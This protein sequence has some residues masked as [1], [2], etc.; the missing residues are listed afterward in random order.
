M[1]TRFVRFNVVG[2]LGIGVRLAVV[3]VLVDRAGMHY[4]VATALAVEVA[5]LHNFFW[6]DR[7]T[8]ADGRDAAT[9]PGRLFLRCLAFHAGNGLVSM[10]GSL[11]IMPLLVGGLHLHYLTANLV[12]IATTGLLN[13]A[14]SDRAVFR[15]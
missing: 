8:F 5:V 15:L 10:L 11:A 3:A 13:F 4:L 12:A 14:L 6:H 1:L 7:W 9:P 2:L